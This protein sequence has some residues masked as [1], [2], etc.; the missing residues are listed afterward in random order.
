MNYFL[1]AAKMSNKIK[2]LTL[3]LLGAISAVGQSEFLLLN[4]ADSLFRLEQY[5]ESAKRYEQYFAKENKAISTSQL[6]KISVAYSLS[7]NAEKAVYWLGKALDKG[8]DDLYLTETRFDLHF[9]PI[10]HTSQWKSFFNQ[11]LQA[12]EKEASSIQYP[13]LRQE[14]LTLWQSD[15][16]YRQ[17]IFGQYNGRAPNELGRVTEAVDRFNAIRLEEIINEIGWPTY[18]KV[19]RDGAHAAWNIIQ[20]AVFNPPLMKR[21]LEEMEKAL[22]VQQVDGID[23]AYLYDRYQAVCYIGKQ[24][25]G[26]VRR[27]SIEDEYL[28]EERR[29]EIGF[30][31]SMADYLGT[32]TPISQEEYLLQE[33]ELKKQYTLNLELGMKAL[34][35]ESFEE[36]A[37][38]FRLVFECYG[39]IQMEDIYQMARVQALLNTPR[40]RFNAIRYIRSLSARD[41]SDLER[42]LSDPAFEV[43]KENESFKEVIQIMEKYNVVEKGSSN[44]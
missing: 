35:N 30:S 42:L 28:L 43:L 25:Y 21:S 33:E 38:Y 13:E 16:F 23:Y 9:D 5:A 1:Q 14:L 11:Q 22:E 3:C 26:I 18:A 6:Y 2:W 37:Q 12:F 39:L 44:N 31:I 4:S 40:S 10:R 19:G 36:A 29:N 20:H 34:N 15:Q 8:Y 32:Y 24:K 41:F 27:V 17:L 7:S